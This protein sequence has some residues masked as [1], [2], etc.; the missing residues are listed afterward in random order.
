LTGLADF[1]DYSLK[2][3]R[4]AVIEEQF[5]IDKIGFLDVALIVDGRSERKWQNDSVFFETLITAYPNLYGAR[6]WKISLSAEERFQPY[7]FGS[8]YEQRTF[9][10][11]SRERIIGQGFANFIILDPS[12]RFFLRTGYVVDLLKDQEHTGEFL[13]PVPEIV[14]LAQTFVVGS[15]YAKALGY[16]AETQLHFGVHWNHL[17]GRKF[18]SRITGQYDFYWAKECRAESVDLEI[19]LPLQLTNQEVIQKTTEGIRKL[20]RAFD[21]TMS[22][23]IVANEVK[24][25]LHLM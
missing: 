1:Q 12:G 13:D 17:K 14:S 6:I 7:P 8:T 25:H 22:E 16:E 19:T 5:D 20:A 21:V 11:P 4:E 24:K 23:Q 9:A 3:F 10:S 15:S 18:E 2:R